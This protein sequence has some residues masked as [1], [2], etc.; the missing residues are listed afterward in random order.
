MEESIKLTKS[1]FEQHVDY[2]NAHGVDTHTEEGT[3]LLSHSERW[4]KLYMDLRKDEREERKIQLEEKKERNVLIKTCVI[5]G[6]TLISVVVIV[7]GEVV[8]NYI[9]RTAIQF[10]GILARIFC[11]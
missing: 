6:V 4:A 2:A 10:F 7:N 5:G 8:G 3:D 1:M 9:A 11:F